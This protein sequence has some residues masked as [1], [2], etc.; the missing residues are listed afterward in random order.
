MHCE[1]HSLKRKYVEALFQ[2]EPLDFIEH[3]LKE[4]FSTGQ[5]S[6]LI[7]LFRPQVSWNAD[8]QGEKSLTQTGF[9]EADLVTNESRANLVN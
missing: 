6:F 8:A 5:P 7:E 1:L 4:P 2:I 3:G 9:M